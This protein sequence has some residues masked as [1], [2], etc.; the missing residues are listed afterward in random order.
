M[1]L[2]AEGR[3]EVAALRLPPAWRDGRIVSSPLGRALETARLL[4]ESREVDVEPRLIEQDFGAWEGQRG[5]D[6]ATE[7]P[8]FQP[9]EN[10]GWDYRPPDGESVGELRDR[11]R[12]ALLAIAEAGRPTVAVC[13]IGV[14]RVVLALAYG[15]DFRGPAP[16]RVKRMR[17]YPLHLDADG[18]P[19]LAGDAVRLEPRRRL[20]P[21]CDLNRGA[22]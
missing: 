20:E 7:D 17:L 1:P 2:D 21:T 6:L 9:I 14:M 19:S 5:A 3:V 16:F 4:S 11:V 12:A 13:H 15:W 18:A 8:R 22:T 10:W